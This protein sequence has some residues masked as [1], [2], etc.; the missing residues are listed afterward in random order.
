M[1]LNGKKSEILAEK[2]LLERDYLIH[3]KNKRV[4]RYEVDLVCQDKDVI[5][6][7]EVKSLASDRIK[8][9]YD[10]VTQSKQMR[11]I[12]VADTILKKHFPGNEARFDIISIIIKN[13]RPQF[14]H[15]KNAFT[16]EINTL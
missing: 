7:V 3:F 13:D 2:Y 14:E 5:V 6:F 12:K 15:L 8:N 10:A 9:P 11:I 4:G 16:P 1:I